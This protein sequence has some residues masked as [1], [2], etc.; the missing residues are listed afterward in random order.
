MLV[1]R[2]DVVVGGGVGCGG[3]LSNEVLL[4]WPPPDNS[5]L[6]LTTAKYR[7]FQKKYIGTRADWGEGSR[8]VYPKKIFTLPP[9][10]KSIQPP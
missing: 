4:C 8:I 5:S 6:T 10:L 2:G 9:S 7:R 3:G 1:A